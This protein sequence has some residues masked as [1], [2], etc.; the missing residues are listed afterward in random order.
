MYQY[1]LKEYSQAVVPGSSNDAGQ[2]PEEHSIPPAPS[3]VSTTRSARSEDDF[4]STKSTKAS[5]YQPKFGKV[6]T[7]SPFESEMPFCTYEEQYGDAYMGGTVKYVYPKGYTNMRP[8]SCPWRLSIVVCLLFTFLSVF[9]IGHCSDR[10]ELD[11]EYAEDLEMDD[12]VTVNEALDVIDADGQWCGSFA[13]KL[14]WGVS[15]IITGL[16]AAYCGI[17]GYVKVRDFAVANGRSQLPGVA[18]GKS[19]YY[20]NIGG[21]ES[22]GEDQ[23]TIYQADGTPQFWG[24]HI[25][26]P[27]QAAVAVTSR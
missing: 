27:T 4:A 23:S 20:V 17:I 10:A 6:A 7:R 12:D 22:K 11:S 14:L 15:M 8:R 2:L 13:L 18:D 19:D 21:I 25:Y 1:A 9:I 26:R 24:A 16:S 3:M 5:S